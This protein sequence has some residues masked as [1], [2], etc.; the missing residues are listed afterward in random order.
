MANWI[1]DNI[2][3]I[4]FAILFYMMY[5]Q[6]NRN[7]EGFESE[8]EK[9][10]ICKNFSTVYCDLKDISD[11]GNELLNNLKN[12]CGIQGEIN[13]DYTPPDSAEPSNEEPSN[14]DENVYIE[15]TP[16]NNINPDSGDSSAVTMDNQGNITKLT[17]DNQPENVG[18]ES[19]D[20]GN[21]AAPPQVN[22]GQQ[23]QAATAG[24][25]EGEG[26]VGQPAAASDDGKEQFSFIPNSMLSRAGAPPR[27]NSQ[28]SFSPFDY[29]QSIR[30]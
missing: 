10:N 8:Q 24:Q 13:C 22:V 11:D 12:S 19:A 17:P 5:R 21:E 20:V 1:Q 28:S 6:N 26:E 15:N 14:E 18:N 25:G 29:M 9:T 27:A 30:K 7:V 3:L 23:G 2:H 16:E 4:I